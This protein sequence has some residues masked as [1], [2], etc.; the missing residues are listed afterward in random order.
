[1]Q[2]AVSISQLLPMFAP[3]FYGKQQGPQMSKKP[4]NW[5]Q[6]AATQ[7]PADGL[8]IKSTMQL[9]PGSHVGAVTR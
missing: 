1:M 4:A 8:L 6:R 9:I 5:I 7:G 3:V 2:S